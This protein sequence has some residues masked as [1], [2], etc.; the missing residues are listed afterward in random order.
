MLLWIIISLCKDLSVEEYNCKCVFED[1][2]LVTV[3]DELYWVSY[4]AIC[5]DTNN[6]IYLIKE[7]LPSYE[8]AQDEVKYLNST[9]VDC[10]S[11][12]VNLKLDK[13][14]DINYTLDIIFLIIAIIGAILLSGLLLLRSIAIITDKT[15]KYTI[16]KDEISL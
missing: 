10:C 5:L 8:E 2:N 11:E 7:Y 1:I 14:N 3:Q 13:C 9:L 12:G 15:S 16:Q 6:S 4:W